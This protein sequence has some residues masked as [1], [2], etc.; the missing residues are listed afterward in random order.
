MIT[1]KKFL[2]ASL[3]LAQLACISDSLAQRIW[4]EAP[5][6]FARG[7]T[8]PASDMENQDR[9]TDLVWITRSDEGA[10]LFNI[11][12]DV[13][14]QF[15]SNSPQGTRWAFA[16]LR[17]NPATIS[18]NDFATLNFA[19]WQTSL[20]SMG[21]LLSNIVNRQGVV[22]LIEDDIYIDIMFTQWGAQGNGSFTY[23]RATAS[24]ITS[25]PTVEEVPIDDEVPLPGFMLVG[26][27]ILLGLIGIRFRKSRA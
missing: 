4:T 21:S 25:P 8:G 13:E 20:G 7:E 22:H 14:T 16:G 9:I 27:S 11:A 18:A 12:N 23:T 5:I 19:N 3:L 10:G 15:F 26:L 1:Q 2:I 17:N 24:A 6:E